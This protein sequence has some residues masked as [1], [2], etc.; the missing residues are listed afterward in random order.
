MSSANQTEADRYYL[1]GYAHGYR[2]RPI[3]ANPTP[4]TPMLQ[5]GWEDG[6]GD[7]KSGA[8]PLADLG[9]SL[10]HKRGEGTFI[11]AIDNPYDTHYTSV[12]IY[13]LHKFPVKAIYQWTER[14]WKFLEVVPASPHRQVL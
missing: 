13:G 7:A 3:V 5:M 2:G 14:N 11:T 6:A 10:H 9:C 1:L 8:L 12:Y 4:P